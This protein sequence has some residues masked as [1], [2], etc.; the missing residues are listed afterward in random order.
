MLMR[1]LDTSRSR[2]GRRRSRRRTIIIAIS[3]ILAVVIGYLLLST[4]P[5][6]WPYRNTLQY[7]VLRKW[8]AVVPGSQA[9]GAGVLAGLVRDPRGNPV[10]QARVLVARRDGMAWSG[11]ADARGSYRIT[12]VPAGNYVPVAGAPGFDDLAV[13]RAGLFGTGIAAGR[14]TR[15]DLTL[16]PSAAPRAPPAEKFRL[17]PPQTLVIEAPLPAKAVERQIRFEVGGK[18]NQVAFYYTPVDGVGALPTLLAVYPGPA[19][20]WKQVSLPLAQAGYAVIAVGPDYALDLEPA[21][22]DLE[23]LIAKLKEGIFPR[24]DPKR[25]AAFGGSYSSLHVFRLLDRGNKDV[26]A[27][28]LLGPPTDL[29]ELR[30][31]FEAG[32]FFPPF[33]LD[34][35]LVALGLPDRNPEPYWRYSARYHARGLNVPVMLIH[36]KIDE[37]VPFTQSQILADELGR[38]GKPYELHILE[39]MGHY[40]L[41]PKRTPAIDDLFRTTTEF[42]KRELR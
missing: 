6:I 22:D 1:V 36:S 27:I 5:R 32:T 17:D 20:M 14:T 8:W 30:R 18:P 19:D 26:R 42:F 39:G 38:L 15:L 33:G 11:E 12:N 40:L 16:T 24:A 10:Y 21:V 7:Y 9:V 35:A 41:E 34:K 25:L 2:T 13:R 23:R 37:I 29:F 28:L 31:Q 4:D 3:A